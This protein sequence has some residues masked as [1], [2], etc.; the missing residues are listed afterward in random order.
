MPAAA[1]A[2]AW[3]CGEGSGSSASR[4]RSAPR[5]PARRRLAAR[6]AAG[7]DLLKVDVLNVIAVG[8]AAH[9]APLGGAA[10]AGRGA[11]LAGAAALAVVLATPA[12]RRRAPPLRP[13]AA[14]RRPPPPP[15]QAPNRLVDVLARL[16]LR[17]LAA[18]QL[19][20][21]QLGGVP[22][23]RRGR[24]AAR[25]RREPA[26]GCGSGLAAALFALGWLG[27]PLAARLR[28]PELLAD[29]AV[30]V[31]DAARGLPRPHRRAPARAGRAPSAGSRWLTLLGRQSLVA[32]IASVELTY[33]ALAVAAEGQRCRS[34]RPC[35]ACSAM[36]A[37]TWAISLAWERY[38]ARRRRA[39][40][41][42]GPGGAG[43]P[44]SRA[45]S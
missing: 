34:A 33:G 39:G 7:A 15:A 10:R 29:L 8:L 30:L 2:A 17:E 13:P 28:V 1:R 40:G 38:R 16:P 31:R 14:G 42:R 6:R 37:L 24:R 18:R 27:G 41:Q 35:S 12:R 19:P 23:R 25:A 26:R 36:A 11:L 5:V 3:R 20:P 4:T 43:T 9:R 45:G 44:L 32:Y 21:L 22:P